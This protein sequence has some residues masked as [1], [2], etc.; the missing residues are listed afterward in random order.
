[1]HGVG[2]QWSLQCMFVQGWDEG[3]VSSV[4]V[5][6]NTYGGGDGCSLSVTVCASICSCM[7]KDGA[8][9]CVC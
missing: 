6:S 4:G 5:H 1:M 8:A 2:W 7:H 3:T 9:A